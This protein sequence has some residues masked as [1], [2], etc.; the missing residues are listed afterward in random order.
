MSGYKGKYDKQYRRRQGG[1]HQV[2]SQQRKDFTV[3][4][5][6]THETRRVSNHAISEAERSLAPDIWSTTLQIVRP[7]LN[8]NFLTIPKEHFMKIEE[9][10]YDF[11]ENAFQ[12][13]SDFNNSQAKTLTDRNA[14][15]P[16]YHDFVKSEC[17]VLLSNTIHVAS[18]GSLSMD[19]FES[20]FGRNHE[21]RDLKTRMLSLVRDFYHTRVLISFKALVEQN[22]SRSSNG[23]NHATTH[24]FNLK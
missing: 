6:S 7:L 11:L 9:A 10:F 13:L 2:V 18:N 16:M 21:L 20:S 19:D 22:I 4:N 17:A 5:L 8:I 23:Q 14:V 3:S 12:R 24:P 15:I 1:G